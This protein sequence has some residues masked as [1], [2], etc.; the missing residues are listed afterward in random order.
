MKMKPILLGLL[1]AGLVAGCGESAEE[2]ATDT[3]MAAKTMSLDDF[4]LVERSTYFGN[5]ERTQGR[6]SPDGSMMSFMAPLDG[7]I[8]VWVAPLGDFA[9]AKPITDDKLRGI[10]SHSWATNGT[11]ILYTRDTG[12]DEDFHIYSVNVET[13][14]SIDL[15]PFEKIRGIFVGSSKYPDEYL[16][17][18]NNRNPAY[19]DVYRV[20]VVSGERDLILEHDRF[21]GFV[22]DMELNIR[23]GLIPTPDGG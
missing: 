7:V 13:G 3:S 8:N 5:P 17:G 15:T 16:V 20:N 4:Q 23:L 18:I 11:H 12:G 6:I 2:A 9:S 1:A 10:G 19:Q 22:A 21:A 14:E